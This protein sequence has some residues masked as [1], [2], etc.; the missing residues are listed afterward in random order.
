MG[1]SLFRPHCHQ[2]VFVLPDSQKQCRL[3]IRDVGGHPVLTKELL[4]KRAQ[5]YQAWVRAYAANHGITM[6]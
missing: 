5:E 6:E 2:R 3:L 4:A 1:L